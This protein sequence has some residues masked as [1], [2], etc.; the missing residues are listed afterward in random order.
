MNNAGR[1][2]VVG[3]IHGALKAFKEVIALC[4]FSKD[5]LLIFLGDYADGWSETPQLIDYLILLKQTHQC[6]FLQGNHDELLLNWLLTKKDNPIWFK[7]G[8]K[9]S[10]DAYLNL[11]DEKIKQH[12]DFL[13]DLKPYLIDSQNR[14][15]VHAGFT[16][17]N[18]IEHEYFPKMF[19]WDRTLWEMALA[20][21]KNLKPN[22]VMYP[23][24][25]LL[26]EE[27]YIGHTP[28]TR[29]NQTIPINIA[30]VWNID[31]GA[32]FWGPL[33]IMD[34]ETKQFWQSKPVTEWYPDENGRN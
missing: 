7:H 26:H 28:V 27:I 32:A 23:K 8:G 2:L 9:A 16:N 31:T 4:E 21:D 22:D 29:I 12:I 13:S 17:P 1:I 10:M 6:V 34:V 33:T 19:H 18:G 5:D 20:M 30:N 14:L 24:R 11:S 25:F 3:D 15:F